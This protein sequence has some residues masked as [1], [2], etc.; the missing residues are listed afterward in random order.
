MTDKPYRPR[1]SIELTEEQAQALRDYI[2][3]GVK[4][5]LFQTIVD[6]VIKMVKKHGQTFVAAILERKI[7]LNKLVKFEMKDGD[8]RRPE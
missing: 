7:E 1:L 5:A 6:D 3:W 8:N 2:P 4:N